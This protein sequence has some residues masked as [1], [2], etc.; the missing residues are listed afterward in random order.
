M[1]SGSRKF[2]LLPQLRMDPSLL[3]CIYSK[4][5]TQLQCLTQNHNV[6]IKKN[7]LYGGL[8]FL[9][10]GSVLGLFL[11][12][13]WV[14]FRTVILNVRSVFLIGSSAIIDALLRCTIDK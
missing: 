8:F 5:Y 2:S 3:I 4:F 9:A 10:A 12:K 6:P 1:L 13:N 7:I 11:G 14:C